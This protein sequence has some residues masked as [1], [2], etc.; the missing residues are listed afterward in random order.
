MLPFWDS[1]HLQI[2]KSLEFYYHIAF[3]M[4]LMIQDERPDI[5]ERLSEA[6]RKRNTLLFAISCK[7]VKGRMQ[8]RYSHT[9]TGTME[10]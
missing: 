8:V 7:F 1:H 2:L 6:I 4:R 9:D 5:N 3:L 10:V